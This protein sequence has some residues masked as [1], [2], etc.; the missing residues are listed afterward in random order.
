[1]SKQDKDSRVPDNADDQKGGPEGTRDARAA[2]R[3]L[4]GQWRPLSFVPRPGPLQRDLH[5]QRSE[6]PRSCWPKRNAIS[7]SYSST[8]GFPWLK[9][10]KG[11][12]SSHCRLL[13]TSSKTVSEDSPQPVSRGQARHEKVADAAPGRNRPP[14]VAPHISGL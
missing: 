12:A 1:M 14:G 5:T 11:P 6:S 10:R 4:L 2:F 8:G 13:L 3:P 7:S 9:R